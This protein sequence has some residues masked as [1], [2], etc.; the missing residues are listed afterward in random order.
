[1]ASLIDRAV[2]IGRGMDGLVATALAPHSAEA[3]ILVNDDVA[4]LLQRW[5][6]LGGFAIQHT[7]ERRDYFVS[8]WRGLS[9]TAAYALAALV[10]GAIVTNCRDV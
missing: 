10:A 4:R 6:P 7:V 1:V 2:V 8:P 3:M 9:V 5:T